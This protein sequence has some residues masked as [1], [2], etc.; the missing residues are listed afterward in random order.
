MS[1]LKI[2][3]TVSLEI[4]AEAYTYKKY[5][6]LVGS[7]F[8]DGRTTNNDNSEGMLNYTK[9]NIRR[10]QRWDKRGKLDTELTE[11]LAGFP[12]DMIWLVLTEGWCG[13][14]AQSLPFIHKMA[15]ASGNIQLKLILRDQ[16]PEVMDRFLTNGSKSVPKLIALDAETVE[17]IGEWGPRPVIAQTTYL[18]E[19]ANPEIENSKATENLHL[20]YARDKGQTLQQEFLTLL[21]EWANK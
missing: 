17:V 18:S 11:R 9:M 3:E 21:D 10:S 16:H 14:A 5:S 15:A 4:L 1:T 2:Q 19:R 6:T 13:D 20:W 12:R 7:L 8:E